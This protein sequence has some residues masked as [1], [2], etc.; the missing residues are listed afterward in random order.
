MSDIHKLQLLPRPKTV[1]LTQGQYHIPAKG[2]IVLADETSQAVLPA[3]R[4]LQRILT[5]TVQLN[6]PLSIGVRPAVAPAF[7]FSYKAGL[8]AG[9]YE[10]HIGGQGITAVSSSPEGAYYAAGTLKQLLEQYG[11]SLPQLVICDE[12]DFAAR[13]LMLDISRNKIPKLETLYGIIEL[14]SDLKLNQLQLYIEGAPF[15]YESFPQVWELET[16]ITG[17]EILLL[18]AY[19]RERYI[20]LVPNQNSFGH[21]EGWLTRP[22]FN[23]LAEIPAGFMLPDHMYDSDLY[24]EGLFMHPGTFNTEDPEVLEL[25]G[26]MYDD[27]LPYFTSDLFNVGCD[28][29]YELGLGQ[30]K[31][32]AD[33]AGKGALYLSFLQKIQALVQTRGKTM[34]FWGDIII[35][36]PELIPQLPEGII[37]ME[38]GYSAAHPFEADT[39]K[40]R[41]AG[42]PFY[43]CPGTS[44][45]NSLTGRTDNMLENL[46][47]AA[48][49]G[50]QNGAIGYLITDW[51]DFGHWQHLPVS[52]PGFVY[53]A[54]LAWNV[55]ENLE[56][57]VAGYL[58]TSVFHDR[59][60]TIGQLLLDLG[61]YYKFESGMIRPNDT[62][63]SMLLRSSL[64]NVLLAEKLSA[65]QLQ[66]L[67]HYIN[68][69]EARLDDLALECRDAGLVLEELGNGIHFVKHALQLTR[70]KQ[71]L[72]G[73]DRSSLAALV[74]AQLHDLDVLLHQY[75]QLWTRRNRLGGLTQS[76][77]RLVRLRGEYA[78]LAAGLAE[79]AAE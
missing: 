53:G 26:T 56:A 20:E 25:L 60:E 7:T 77:S 73:A 64:D 22:E 29:T 76:V 72:A 62:E 42:I 19:C 68:G 38:W 50:K 46:R 16:P 1:T 18:D 12:P 51:G 52:Y 57:D 4:R 9:A 21:M 54:A 78:A 66:Q 55:E 75:R 33:S 31:A 5:Q 36:H 30:T 14:M 15:A 34:Q 70:L 41:E 27:L 79:A 48:V 32:L 44:S 23:H 3:A 69:I 35:Q 2:A 58:N 11:R 10:I 61:N 28:E 8:P 59:S 71:Q 45:W 49:H 74:Q 65:Q 67:E 43:V 63:M 6:L 24:P 39:L 13:G 37:A 47:S 40:F 17:E